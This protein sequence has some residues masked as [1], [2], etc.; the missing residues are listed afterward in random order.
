[1]GG[2]PVPRFETT[3][4]LTT[5]GSAPIDPVDQRL[6]LG[7]GQLVICLPATARHADTASA[8]KRVDGGRRESSCARSYLKPL[9]KAYDFPRSCDLCCYGF[10]QATG[11]IANPVLVTRETQQP[12]G[13]PGAFCIDGLGGAEPVTVTRP[14]IRPPRPPV[15]HLV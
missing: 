6:V 3:S 14:D 10:E 7:C 9:W 12:S 15:S 13:I 11:R 8:F 1:M 4:N 2:P 5:T